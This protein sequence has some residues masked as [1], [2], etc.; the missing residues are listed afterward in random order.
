[1]D[2]ARSA[3]AVPQKS[4][5]MTFIIGNLLCS[6]GFVSGNLPA[7]HLIP[8]LQ[9]VGWV[10]FPSLQHLSWAAQ[11]LQYQEDLSKRLQE[12]DTLVVP[13]FENEVNI[14]TSALPLQCFKD[15][16]AT[17]SSIQ[18]DNLKFMHTACYISAPS[19]CCTLETET[20]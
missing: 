6:L 14:L 15:L 7:E 12:K 19:T 13:I 2:K 11:W 3:Q 20:R 8:C 5:Q 10:K 4:N 9:E 18:S 1:M 17:L 16:E